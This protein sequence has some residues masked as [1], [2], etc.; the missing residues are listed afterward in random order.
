M[1]ITKEMTEAAYF[2]GKDV[3]LGK[4]SRQ[5]AISHLSKEFGIAQ[6]SSGDFIT[7]FQHMVNGRKY[8]RTLNNFST[9]HFLTKICED[10]DLETYKNAIQAGYL[11]VEYYAQIPKGGNLKG[12]KK[13]LD[14]HSRNFEEISTPDLFVEDRNN[15]EYQKAISKSIGR[16]KSQ[17]EAKE[18]KKT[19][20]INGQSVY[21]RN[22]SYAKQALHDADYLCEISDSHKTFIQRFSHANFT[23]AHHLVPLKYHADFDVS[24]DIPS[25]IISLCPNCHRM[26][27]FGQLSEIKSL[28]KQLLENRIERLESCGIKINDKQLYRYYR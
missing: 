7:N 18:K 6:G 2:A 13:I 20:T 1:K 3:F 26:L 15:Y 11:H 23:E 21:P 12:I 17:D 24:L 4:M 27:H 28:L 9:D 10:F 8:T 25:N 19:K 5:E 16:N 22:P 14:N